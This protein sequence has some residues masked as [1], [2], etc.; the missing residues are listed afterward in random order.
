[1][2]TPDLATWSKVVTGLRAGE[3]AWLY[4]YRPQPEPASSFLVKVAVEA[5]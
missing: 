4:V 1:V 3:A 2:P 5:P